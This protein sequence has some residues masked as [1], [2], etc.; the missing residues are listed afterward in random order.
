MTKQI[1]AVTQENLTN[2]I[3]SGEMGSYRQLRDQSRLKSIR[4][5]SKK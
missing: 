5:A 1:E 4:F 3:V 2:R